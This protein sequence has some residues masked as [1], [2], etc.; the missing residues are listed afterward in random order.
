[1]RPWGAGYAS[2]TLPFDA[3]RLAGVRSALRQLVMKKRAKK[4]ADIQ[5]RKRRPR[6]G[7]KKVETTRVAVEPYEQREGAP[8]TLEAAL[9]DLDPV[10]RAI[11][12]ARSRSEKR[13]W[14]RPALPSRRRG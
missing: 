1:V 2:L 14:S 4:T 9:I 10:M 7:T 6:R 13:C 8:M 12:V 3:P 11:I 5:F